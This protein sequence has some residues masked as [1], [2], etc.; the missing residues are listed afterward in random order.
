MPLAPWQIPLQQEGRCIECGSRKTN[1][2]KKDIRPPIILCRDCKKH[3]ISAQQTGKGR[4]QKCDGGRM[5]SQE[6]I[7]IIHGVDRG[8]AEQQKDG[9]DP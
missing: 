9:D 7:S 2:Y 4:F 8:T 3:T 6:F 5:Q 1:Y